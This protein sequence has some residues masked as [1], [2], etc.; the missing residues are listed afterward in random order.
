[1]LVDILM[2]FAI[3]LGVVLL[4]LVGF[5]LLKTALF[6]PAQKEVKPS[7]FP[8]ID[9]QSVAERL[10]LAVQFKTISHHDP[11]K[12]DA[13]AFLGLHR[14]LQT[15]YPQVHDKLKIEKVNDYSLLYTWEGKNPDLK[16]VMLI[17]HLDVVPA[18]EDENAAWTHPPFSGEIADGY[19]WGRG[20]MD[21]KNGV[22]SILEAVE[23]L[24]KNEFQP[25]RTVYLGFGHDEEVS[26]VHGAKAI[27]ALL[28]SRG[29]R[30][31]SVLDEG[32]GVIADFLPGIE[33]HVGAIG[34]SEKG[35]LSLRLAVEKD[36]GHSSVPP[37]ET[38]IGI[39]SR[40]IANLESRQMPAHLEIVEFL[41]SYIGAALPFGQ[42]LMFANTWL[43]GGLLKKR[44]A[45]TGIMNASIRTTTAPTIINAGVKDNVLPSKAEA[46]VNFRILPGDDI[47]SVFQMVQERIDDERVKLLPYQGDVLEGEAGWDP[48][49]VADTESPYFLRLTRLIKEVYPGTLTVPYLVTGATDARH[50]APLTDNALRFAPMQMTNGDL[51][52]MHGIDERLSL[53]NCENMVKFCIGYIEEI[54]SLPAEVD[55]MEADEE[56]LPD[57]DFDEDVLIP[58]DFEDEISETID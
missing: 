2:P 28:E 23:H 48:T 37:Q 49:P 51:M 19:V 38:A 30:L 10:G 13:D 43:F 31:G 39:L 47:R 22:I 33:A 41:M 3:I 32:G 5:I 17:S 12:I 45:K 4:F 54:S 57:V 56:P 18:D 55:A 40:A 29:V 52:R 7:E 27:V 24:L 53:E 15:L 25:D 44:L 6:S 16:P 58:E 21:D 50:Y 20:T 34:I 36:G 11:T 42:R 14:L 26:G 8:E 46:V 1:M 9:A 35:Y